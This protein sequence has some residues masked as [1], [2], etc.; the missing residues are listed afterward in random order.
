MSEEDAFQAALDAD[1]DDHHTRLVFADWLDD[2]DDPR[3]PGYRA[4]GM[5]EHRPSKWAAFRQW[6]WWKWKDGGYAERHP[7]MLPADWFNAIPGRKDSGVAW[8]AGHQQLSR[9]SAEDA[10][11]LAF[12]TLPPA[13]RDELLS[14]KA[15]PA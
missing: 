5:G 13:R 9:R 3:G 12:A 8:P 6:F 1:P 15:V 2:R 7:D 10:A 4:L 14:G 11:A